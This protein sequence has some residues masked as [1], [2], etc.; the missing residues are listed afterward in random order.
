MKFA[1]SLRLKAGH[2]KPMEYINFM[3]TLFGKSLQKTDSFLIKEIQ[4]DGKLARKV[5]A[6]MVHR[7]T[8]K[9]RTLKDFK[10]T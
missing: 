2:H 10:Y 1:K 5:K 6:S 3:M 9:V 8:S 7:I 4:M